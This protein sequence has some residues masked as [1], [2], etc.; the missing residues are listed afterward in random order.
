MGFWAFEHGPGLIYTFHE[1]IIY[2]DFCKILINRLYKAM[3][4]AA[5]WFSFR[6]PHFC[7]LKVAR[8]P[9][10]ADI[11]LDLKLYRRAAFES[12]V[13]RLCDLEDKGDQGAISRRDPLPPPPR[14]VLEKTV[15]VEGLPKDATIQW[16]QVKLWFLGNIWTNALIFRSHFYVC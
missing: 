3:T 11:S 9:E 2:I 7:K 16:L 5:I 8:K 6:I 15:Y 1:A 14:D 13:L 4:I 10:K 12:K